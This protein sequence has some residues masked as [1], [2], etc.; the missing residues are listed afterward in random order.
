MI[1]VDM[2]ILVLIRLVNVRVQTPPLWIEKNPAWE[3]LDYIMDNPY[4]PLSANYAEWSRDIIEN[5]LTKVV[6]ADP[7]SVI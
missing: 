3:A 5:S 7:N 6:I 1:Y 4:L 2:Y